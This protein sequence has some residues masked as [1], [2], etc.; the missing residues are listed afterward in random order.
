MKKLVDTKWDSFYCSASRRRQRAY[1]KIFHPD[2]CRP[3]PPSPILSAAEQSKTHRDKLRSLLRICKWTAQCAVLRGYRLN[4]RLEMAFPF[5]VL[6]EET[7]YRSVRQRI[8]EARI[9]I[10]ITVKRHRISETLTAYERSGYESW[11]P[12]VFSS[13][14]V[15][16]CGGWIVQRLA[17]SPRP[18]RAV[19]Y[20]RQMIIDI[21]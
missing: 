21:G 3:L 6:G 20:Y 15:G 5:R 18:G 11:C 2:Y 4:P 10:V 16:G 8:L 19:V 7:Q 13:P 17:W 14:F 12:L 1:C 9:G